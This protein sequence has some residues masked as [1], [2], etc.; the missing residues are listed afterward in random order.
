MTPPP[1]VAVRPEPAPRAPRRGPSRW[2]VVAIVAAVVALAAGVAALA[3]TLPSLARDGRATLTNDAT[4]TF[5]L[6]TTHPG[7]IAPGDVDA[8]VD[9]DRIATADVRVL[10]GGR[11]IELRPAPLAD[12]DHQVRVDVHGAGLLRRTLHTTWKTTVDT[13]APAATIVAPRPAGSADSAYVAP[14]VAEVATS[15]MTLVV[16]AE[17]GS[18]LEVTSSAATAADPVRA[19]PVDGTRRTLDVPLPQGPQVVTVR[20]TD[21]AGTE[22]VRRLK[23]LVDT[24]GPKV[25]V[26]SPPVVTT[27]K[28]G[29]TVAASD[30]HGADLSVRLD[31]RE[32][33][34]GLTAGET[35]PAP[36]AAA[37]DATD[38]PDTADG[39][40]T[41]PPTDDATTPTGGSDEGSDAGDGDLAPIAGTWTLTLDEPA[42]EGRHVLE[43][44]G[45]DS[46]GKV[47]RTTRAFVVDSSEALGESAGLR[48][49]ARGADVVALQGALITQGGA[50]KAGLAADMTARSYGA[51]TRA[52]VQHFQSSRGMEADGVAGADTIAALTLKI[53]VDRGANT[54]TLYRMGKVVKTYGVA[55]GQPSF[56]TPAG[57]FKIQSMQK[58][59]TWTPPDS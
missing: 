21:R 29:L 15:H 41:T 38:A 37:A 46:L 36:F 19:E 16:G 43:V 50:S 49:G 28:L 5:T 13:T 4:P 27:A 20:A 32:V 6:R 57:Q 47:S 33:E 31:G 35:T 14:G 59:P 2:I 11:R 8:R 7:S 51:G 12:G 54:L 34:A 58:N 10:S 44:V 17:P 56:P 1:P 18:K 30:P 3:L 52:A 39:D 53:V 26:T 48:A 45:T 25:T 42:Y 55:T 24:T 23:V 40:G 22:Q 9:G